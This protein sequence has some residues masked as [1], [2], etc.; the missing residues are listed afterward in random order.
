MPTIITVHMTNTHVNSTPRHGISAGTV[1]RSAKSTVSEHPTASRLL[2]AIVVSAGDDPP[3]P[4][5]P[6][7]PPR[8]IC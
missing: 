4:V 7:E 6:A 8:T 5:V 1:S 3:G 2:D